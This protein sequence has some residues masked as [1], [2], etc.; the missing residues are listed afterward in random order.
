MHEVGPGSLCIIGRQIARK[1][2]RFNTVK[3]CV[4]FDFTQIGTVLQRDGKLRFPIA[5]EEPGIYQFTIRDKIYVGETD[6]LRR[7]FQ[8]YRTPGPSQQTNIRMNYSILTALNEGFEVVVSTIEQAT[9]NVD[10]IDSPLD[11]SRK[12][13]RLLVESAV[14]SAAHLRGQLVE[15]L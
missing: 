2:H 15:N 4:S 8:H 11:L 12:S 6:R 10:G 14:L 7:R 3:V 9:I 1:G 13:G 5:P